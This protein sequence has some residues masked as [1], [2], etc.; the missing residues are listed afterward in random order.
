M[1]YWNVRLKVVSFLE[2]SQ[3]Y[4]ICI[5]CWYYVT[6]SWLEFEVRIVQV[7]TWSVLPHVLYNLLVVLNIYFYRTNCVRSL[8]SFIH[9]FI[10]S[11]HVWRGTNW[12]T[13]LNLSFF[14]HPIFAIQS[15]CI[16][17]I[18]SVKP[19]KN[20]IQLISLLL[21][22]CGKFTFISYWTSINGVL[23]NTSLYYSWG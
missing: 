19:C 17:H 3:V 8:A 2:T 20:N 23:S 5:V 1:L 21:E 15:V 22:N 11:Q 18:V 6:R 12:T 7:Y 14:L 10:H 9:S 4:F 13:G 16:F